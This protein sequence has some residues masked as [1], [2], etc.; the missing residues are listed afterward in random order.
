MCDA[1][2]PEHPRDILCR[3]GLYA[4]RRLGQNFLVSHRIMERMVE[5]A[6]VEPEDAVLEVGSG[7]GRLT[8]CLASRAHVVVG[9]E[10]DCGLYE[11]A[12]QRL[13]GF[14]NVSLLCCDFLCGK[15]KINAAVTET[16]LKA[17]GEPRQGNGR[18]VKV[19]SNMPY[20]I[21]SP[22]IIN[23]LEWEVPVQEMAVMLQAEVADRL[24]A[25]PGTSEYGPLA[26]LAGYFSDV[27]RLFAVPA[28]A[29]WPRPA[30]SSSFVRFTPRPP[31]H[32]ARDYGLFSEVARKLFQ[33]RRKTL[34]RALSLGWGKE[35]ATAALEKARLEPICR[36]DS[37]RIG[38]LLTL[39]D[40]LAC[41][42]SDARGPSTG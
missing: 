18:S 22:A 40:A 5:L 15:H 42:T 11:V 2:P 23:L 19:V 4:R 12:R 10:I 27:E 31:P 28:S 17:R 37:L 21:S 9:V 41:L 36:P 14:D 34:A 32:R 8:A 26:V 24:L 35:K 39:A 30:V 33:N 13:A 3:R 16:V 6:R 38:D 29:F 20:G 25:P 1:R 7:L